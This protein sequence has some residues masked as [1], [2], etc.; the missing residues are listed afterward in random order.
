MILDD[1]HATFRP[2]YQKENRLVSQYSSQSYNILQTHNQE[3]F[4]AGQFF[5][6]Q[7]TWITFPYSTKKTGLRMENIFARN[8]FS[9]ETLKKFILSG[10]F[11]QQITTIRAFFFEIRAL[12]SIFQKRAGEISPNPSPPPF[13]QLQACSFKIKLSVPRYPRDARLS[14]TILS[15]FII[16]FTQKKMGITHKFSGAFTDPM[17]YCYKSQLMKVLFLLLLSYF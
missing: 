11:Y 13:L 17:P 9:Q 7:G 5:Q 10:K 15:A 2:F 3:L 16:V 14:F 6:N 12:F 8:N 1:N 4:R